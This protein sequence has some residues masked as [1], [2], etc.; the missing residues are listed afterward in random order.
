MIKVMMPVG[1]PGSGKST[2]AK[3]EIAKDPENWA[4]VN[5]DDIRAMLNGSVWS[6]DYEK[7]VSDIRN[8]LIREA[9]KR[10]K[11][12]I[13]DNLNLNKRHFNDVVEIAKSLNKDIQVIEKSFFVEL[14]EAIARDAKREG[15]AQVGESVIKKW[16][17][18][19]GGNQHKFYKPKTEICLVGQYGGSSLAPVAPAF[20]LDLPT[21]VVCDLDGTISLF[22]CI[23]KKGRKVIRHP[24]APSRS[25]YDGT[26]CDKDLPNEAVVEAI[27]MAH[28]C[29]KKIVFC[30]GRYDTY[31]TQ[32]RI[33]LDRCLEGIPYELF[34]RKTGDMR[35]DNIIKEEI[36][37]D[38]IEPSF[39]VLF[40]L[41]DRDSVVKFWRSKGLACFQ[42]AE[43]EF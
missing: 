39:N 2:W 15:K 26:H 37:N 4:R 21:A 31:E 40:V 28:A 13:V 27:K 25:P 18:E 32:T 14:D 9:L 41:D 38:K 42:V 17:K 43:G 5:N 20:K 30:S 36:Y 35:A 7:F 8:H 16:W 19:S 22:N 24:E 3:A 33:F 11:N 34:M 23:D 12:V 6:S 1:I 10:N 29:G